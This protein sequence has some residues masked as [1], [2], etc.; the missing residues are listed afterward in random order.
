[1]GV[2]KVF[3]NG[4]RAVQDLDLFVR[5]GEMLFV[6]G[7]S[8][9]GKSTLFRLM[10]GMT[11]PTAGKILIEG[12]DL[13]AMNRMRLRA[14]R[15]RMGVIFQDFR[16]I[17]GHTARENVELGM[18]VLGIS[19]RVIRKRAVEYLDYLELT[20]KANADVETLSWGQRQRLAAA[21]ALAREPEIILADE[22]TGN[23]DAYLSQRVLDLLLKAHAEGATVI[24]VTHAQSVLD[25]SAFRIATLEEGRLIADTEAVDQGGGA[26]A[27]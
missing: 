8:G 2:T 20:E 19:P 3:P 22:P 4:T 24:V 25:Q 1:M 18:R 7:K 11:L 26:H 13:A 17:R 23:L 15:R 6:R 21:R 27:T 5:E 9:A 14:L 10:M 16:L 12:C